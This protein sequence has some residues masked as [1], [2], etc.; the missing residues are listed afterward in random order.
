M[1]EDASSIV[2]WQHLM[3]S[4][5]EQ[6]LPSSTADPLDRVRWAASHLAEYIDRWV[7]F[8]EHP[9]V[10]SQPNSFVFESGLF[11]VIGLG[12][13]LLERESASAALPGHAQETRAKLVSVHKR[14][15]E[16]R[17]LSLR[18]LLQQ[19]GTQL[20]AELEAQG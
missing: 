20:C 2:E 14:L 6:A 17:D 1:T 10:T 16:G 7:G 5:L 12:V 13:D 8:A 4:R 18:Q 15:S 9:A 3:E 19:L 11:G